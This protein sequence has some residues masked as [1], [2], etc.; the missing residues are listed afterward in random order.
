MVK[1]LIYYEGRTD[2]QIKIRGHRVDLSEV[3]KNISSLDYIDKSVSLCYHAGEI[4]QAL[5]GFVVLR[6]DLNT[7]KTAVQIEMDL[8]QRLASY[9]VPQIIVVDSVPLLINGKVDR[10]TLLKT[11]EKLSSQQNSIS[12]QTISLENVPNDQIKIAEDLMKTVAH[13]IGHSIRSQ[14]TIDSNFYDLGGNSLNSIYTVSQLRKKGYCISI[15]DFITSKTLREILNFISKRSVLTDSSYNKDDLKINSNLSLTSMPLK[16][17]HKSDTIEIITTSFYEKADIEQFIK[18]EIKRSDYS[19][20][21]EDIWNDL[22]EK[23]LSFAVFDQNGRMV[24][25]S[26]NFDAH[27]EPPVTVKSKLIYVFEF[28]EYLEGPIR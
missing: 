4:D 9:M 17:E 24:G 2:S 15:T 23:E 26:L 10:Q 6:N 5:L 25:V 12:E 14:I 13:C 19:D 3:E 16:N 21:L 22:L 7:N 20:I 11:Y 1:G 18:N 28:L 27:D 8:K